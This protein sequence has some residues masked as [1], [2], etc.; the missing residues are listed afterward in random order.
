MGLTKRTLP[1]LIE[2]LEKYKERNGKILMLGNQDMFFDKVYFY[3]VMARIIP[4]GGGK[5]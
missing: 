4:L 2:Y 3:E 1:V 5:R